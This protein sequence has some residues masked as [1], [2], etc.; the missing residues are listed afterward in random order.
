MKFKKI[1]V[2][3]F[4]FL[5]AL[6]GVVILK[7]TYLPFM[8]Q[9]NSFIIRNYFLLSLILC[10]VFFVLLSKSTITKHFLVKTAVVIYMILLLYNVYVSSIFYAGYSERIIKKYGKNTFVVST[11][12]P[13]FGVCKTRYKVIR[14]SFFFFQKEIYIIGCNK[15]S[16]SE[17]TGGRLKV[18]I[19]IAPLFEQQKT[20]V[21]SVL[22]RYE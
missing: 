8:P 22:I 18:K 21:D 19:E 1:Q 7:M 11:Y 16:I 5:L 2:I 15:Y 6:L 12:R 4:S 9:V 10:I 13:F 20:H 3:K 17:E 14:R